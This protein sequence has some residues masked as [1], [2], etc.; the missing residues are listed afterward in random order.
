MKRFMLFLSLILVVLLNMDISFAQSTKEA[1]RSLQKL[2]AK[3][4]VGISYRDYVSVLGDAKFEV[5]LFL[6]SRQ[7]K[8]DKLADS[9]MQAM[10]HYQMAKTVWQVKIDKMYLGRLPSVSN[11]IFVDNEDDKEL[12]DLNSL[13]RRYPNIKNEIR[14]GP[15]GRDIHIETAIQIIWAEANKEL[16][17]AITLLP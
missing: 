15:M 4:E 14:K 6:Q 2:Q 12:I 13:F 9:I 11:F 3:T 17:K 8:N 10:E 5:N 16:K 7:A 1:I